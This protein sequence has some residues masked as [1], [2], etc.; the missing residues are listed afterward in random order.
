MELNLFEKRSAYEWAI[1]QR[2]AMRVPAVIYARL[3]PSATRGAEDLAEV[4]A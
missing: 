2:G 3:V 4:F 1:P